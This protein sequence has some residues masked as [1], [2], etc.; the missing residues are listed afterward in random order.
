MK[1]FVLLFIALLTISLG[2]IAQVKFVVYFKDGQKT[3]FLSS[4]V[5]SVTFI[6]NSEDIENKKIKYAVE[7]ASWVTYSSDEYEP[8]N[9]VVNKSVIERGDDAKY[10]LSQMYYTNDELQE[11]YIVTSEGN[12]DNYQLIFPENRE[13]NF[14]YIWYDDA[15][16]KIKE[17]I[18][19]EDYKCICEY[20]D[21]D[22]FVSDKQ[23]YQDKLVRSA[24]YSYNGLV[25]YGEVI[26]YSFTDND[27][28]DVIEKDTITYT[29]YTYTQEKE[30]RRTSQ[31]L[32]GFKDTY[33][34]TALYEIGT[35]GPVKIESSEVRF[36]QYGAKLSESNQVQIFTWIDELNNTFISEYETNS[37][38]SEYNYKNRVEGYIKYTY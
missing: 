23:Y 37:Y 15:R 9:K 6:N 2:I 38:N 33:V 34:Y 20:D 21:K 31:Y 24:V 25:R 18:S 27:K 26:N 29:D 35:Y 11:K 19:S 22:R 32:V 5:D 17:N 3:E 4:R 7:E 36:N 10:V 30:V 14:T 16:T 1:K 12:K 13:H 28:I 8:I